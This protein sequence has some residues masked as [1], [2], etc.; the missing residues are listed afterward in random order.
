MSNHTPGPWYW[1]FDRD[2]KASIQSYSDSEPVMDDRKC[3]SLYDRCLIAA[4]PDLFRAQSMGSQINTPDF[5]DWMADRLVHVYGE[6][7]E[8]DFVKSLRERARIGRRAMN[9]AIGDNP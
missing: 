4:A 7:P 6:N 5:L 8:V 2:G 3:P 1:D 9:K